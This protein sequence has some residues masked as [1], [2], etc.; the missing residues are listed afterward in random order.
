MQ[1]AQP[2]FLF[3][4]FFIPLMLVLYFWGQRQKKRDLQAMVSSSLQP[5]IVPQKTRI[6]S[7]FRMGLLLM[8]FT[9]GVLAL[10]QP[11]WG[12]QWQEV[13]QRGTDI[14]IAIDLS[15]SMLA[16]DV[17]PD[18]LTRAKREVTDLLQIIEGDPVGLIA[19]AGASF[20][21]SPLT[22]DYGAIQIFLDSL[23]TSLIPVQGTAIDSVI[24]TAKQAFAKTPPESRALI[25]ITDG[26]DHS[27][28]TS[29]A[30]R[31]A[32]AEGIQIFVIGVGKPKALRFPSQKV[33]F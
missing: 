33:V 32:N 28:K 31:L 11:Q 10:A 9:M 2:S 4:L 16:Q 5:G 21:Q 24:Q 12:F 30:I 14:L 8:G 29:E 7:A 26:E 6:L 23:D 15:Q 27:E 22:L 25:L 1:W 3:G 20:L 17:S 13:H 18:R 19:F